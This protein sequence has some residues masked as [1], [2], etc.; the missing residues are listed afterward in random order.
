[1][2]RRGAPRG[3]RSFDTFAY[4]LM[5]HGLR[6]VLTTVFRPV[7]RGRRGRGRAASA[8]G[9]RPFPVLA[10]GKPGRDPGEPGRAVGEHTFWRGS[11]WGR[12]V[13]LQGDST[14]TKYDLFEIDGPRLLYWGT[15]RG[16]GYHD[17]EESHSFASPFLWMDRWMGVGDFRQQRVTDSLL[18]PRL[19]RVANSAGLTLRVEV[20]AHHDAWR[21]PDSGIR[22]EDVLEVSY[23][24]RYPAESS[25]EVYHLGHGLG[26]IRFE[27]LNRLEPSGVHYQYAESFDRFAPPEEPARPWFDPFDNRTYVPN[28]YGQDFRV[29][30]GEGGAVGRHLRGWSGSARAEVTTD[31]GDAGTGPW[32]IVLRGGEPRGDPSADHLV[33]S[34]WIPVTPG[35]RY[36][37]S[38]RVW[39]ESAADNVYLDF[40]DGTGMDEGFEDAQAMAAGTGGW[41][42]VAAEATVG[43]ATA[44]VRVRGVR[45][46]ANRGDAWFDGI[47]LQRIDDAEKPRPRRRRLPRP[48]APRRAGRG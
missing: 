17:S 18:D 30:P 31:R 45:D 46:G 20:V 37:L 43:A 38:G 40:D 35:R 16:N 25:K 48:R 6:G 28:G 15:F 5:P 2:S 21:D 47:T 29:P 34:D 9:P 13:A 1:M 10:P 12:T 7:P 19:R 41:E 39:R 26:T 42:R 23:W 36:R 32:K 3:K 11:L 24:G 4:W 27:T 33:T 8:P 44:A 14:F 22:Y